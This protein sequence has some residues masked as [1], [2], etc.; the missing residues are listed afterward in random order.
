MTDVACSLKDY[1]FITAY[2]VVWELLKYDIIS[3]KVYYLD[4][5]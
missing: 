4:W 2:E 3:T 1:T 5:L